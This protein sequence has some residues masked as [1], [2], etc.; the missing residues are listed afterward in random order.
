M[1]ATANPVS[2]IFRLVKLERKEISAIYFYAILNGL[3]QLSL[4]VGVQAII[5]FVLGGSMSTS[6]VILI[7]LVVA[8][9]FFTGLLQVGQM[10]LIEKIQ[11]NIF[12]RYSFELADRIPRLDLKKT[13]AYYIPE[14]VN[15]FFEIPSL[16]KGLA[17]LLLDIPTASIQ[18][19]F[20]LILLSFYHP[21][22]ILFGMILV[23]ILWL[24]LYY[25]G[26]KGLQTS[27]TESAYKYGVAA[28]LEEMG[29]LI[30]SFKFSKGSVINMQKTDEK[31][32]GYLDARNSHFSILQFQ[33]KVLIAFKVLITASMLIIGSLLLVNQQ[34]NIGQF[35]AAEIVIIS[36][37]A[38]VEKLIGNLDSVY[39][40]LTSVDK[41]A[42]IT[43][44]PVETSG[45][46]IL[47]EKREGLSVEAEK[48]SFAYDDEKYVLKDAS[49]RIDAGE[50]VCITGKE[51][52]GK[53]TLLKLVSGSYQGFEGSL[54]LNRLPVGNYELKSLREQ[55]GILLNQQDIFHGSL[56]E[57]ITMGQPGIDL[58]QVIRLFGEVGLAN[59]LGTLPQGFDTW[60]DPTGKRLSRNV[61]NKIL[62]VRALVGQ[63]RLLLLE[64][65][66]THIEEPFRSRIIRLLLNDYP[67]TTILVVSADPEFTSRCSKVID[68]NCD[69]CIVKTN[70][71]SN[72]E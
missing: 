29:R 39:D 30:K 35:I 58:Q 64:E 31:V 68:V 25:T 65:P 44:K 5:G 50:T 28:W 14:L 2:R 62:L 13:D 49:F 59:F 40:V 45:S 61:V 63:P 55:T 9:V 6:L 36:I 21:A 18:I 32:S 26:N 15:R 72:H 69:G 43:D 22:F 42:K 33:F 71:S 20:G 38:S 12:V 16:Q 19:V 53:S 10:Q 3:I 57:N 4:P 52:S 24:I 70:K 67:H 7:G 41:I 11:Q 54:L 56:L 37:I 46:Y 1:S 8:G 27:L 51:G 17:K 66:W 34:L 60:L 47:P 48:V 23:L